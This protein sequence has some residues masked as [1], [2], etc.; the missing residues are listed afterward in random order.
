[1][2]LRANQ[3]CFPSRQAIKIKIFTNCVRCSFLKFFFFSFRF[4]L[5]SS[6]CLSWRFGIWR[7]EIRWR[8]CEFL[9]ISKKW[10]KRNSH[11]YTKILINSKRL[12]RQTHGAMRMIRFDSIRFD[13]IRIEPMKCMHRHAHW[14]WKKNGN[15]FPDAHRKYLYLYR[16]LCL[17]LWL[18]VRSICCSVAL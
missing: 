11:K 14:A 5:S 3:K 12:R 8:R 1:V 18:W 16:Y 10:E 13:S 15:R 7:T 6:F 2:H 4:F 17:W 9:H